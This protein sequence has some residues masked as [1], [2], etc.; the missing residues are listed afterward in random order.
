[1][2]YRLGCYN[3]DGSLECLCMAKTKEEAKRKYED[4]KEKWRCTIWVQ[5]IEF[6]DPRE[7]FKEA[8]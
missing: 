1:M 3:T 5:K 2:K 7:E 4:L 6:V 8:E